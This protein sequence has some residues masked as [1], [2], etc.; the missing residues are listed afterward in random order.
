MGQPH[1]P[2]PPLLDPA[3][4]PDPTGRY[5]ARY[6][7]GRKWTSH[8]SHY[9]ATGADPLLRARWDRLWVRVLLRLIFWGAVIG[10]GFWAYREYWPT[11]DR[12]LEAD[13]GLATASALRLTDLPV[14]TWSLSTTPLVS[15]LNLPVDDEGQVA[16]ASCEGL[17]DVVSDATDEPRQPASFQG[18]NGL[19]T[20]AHATTVA[21]G[22]GLGEDYLAELRAPESGACLAVLW[23]D[24]LRAS[25]SEL[26]LT[27]TRPMSDPAFGDEAVWWRLAGDV[28]SGAFVLQMFVDVVVVRVD[29]VITEYAFSGTIEAVGADIQ[30]DV[31][32]LQ[33]ARLRELLD[34]FDGP[35]EDEEEDG[36]DGDE[37]GEV[38]GPVI[39]TG[40]LPE[41]AGSGADSPD[42][43]GGA[44][45]GAATDGG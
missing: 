35:D 14:G 30:R 29:R 15:P 40:E 10:A 3:W 45:D 18:P 1:L 26:T 19:T 23:A 28:E 2:P 37:L 22:T 44:T 24:A 8:I 12:D 32:R 6:W 36:G 43:G 33:V 31:I 13:T 38:P 42:T 27:A 17:A 7:D 16:V 5:E 20:I 9:G 11:D 4:Y 34:A 39:D 25:G 21:G 41:P